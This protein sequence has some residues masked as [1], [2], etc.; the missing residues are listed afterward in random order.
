MLNDIHSLEEYL[1]YK[2]DGD[3][4]FFFQKNGE[5]V[6]WSR[7]DISLQF[8]FID[9]IRKM[10]VIRP[11]CSLFKEEKNNYYPISLSFEEIEMAKGN[12]IN[13][14]LLNICANYVSNILKEEEKIKEETFFPYFKGID[15]NVE[16]K[17][18]II[19]L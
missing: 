17:Y 12:S 10:V 13:G 14:K 18:N 9:K 7:A 11:Y 2:D 8:V 4:E 3:V 15:R 1:K 16:R 19:F 6:D 5:S